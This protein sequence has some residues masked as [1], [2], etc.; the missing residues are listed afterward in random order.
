MVDSNVFE[1]GKIVS[2]FDQNKYLVILGVLLGCFLALKKI[3][4]EC[5]SSRQRLDNMDPPRC[6]LEN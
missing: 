4:A 6:A 3:L 5:T 1:Q 2:S